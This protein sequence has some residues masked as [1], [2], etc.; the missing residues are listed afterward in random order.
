M[1]NIHWKSGF[2]RGIYLVLTIL[3]VWAIAERILWENIEETIIDLIIPSGGEIT[4]SYQE[5]EWTVERLSADITVESTIGTGYF[6][7]DNIISARSLPKEEPIR[8]RAEAIS[9]E[10]YPASKNTLYLNVEYRD[11]F[12][13]TYFLDRGWGDFQGIYEAVGRLLEE[14]ENEKLNG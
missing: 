5:D 4:I 6:V 13:R 9:F 7:I 2:K 3:A 14:L 1:K 11:F 12:Y 8:F 10:I